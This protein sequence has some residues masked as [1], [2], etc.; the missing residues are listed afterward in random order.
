M[1][2]PSWFAKKS[3]C[4]TV[5]IGE[6]FSHRSATERSAKDVLSVVTLPLFQRWCRREIFNWLQ[7]SQLEK[8]EKV[9]KIISSFIPQNLWRSIECWAFS[10]S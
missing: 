4:T 6:I 1:D 9:G 8:Y 3:N 5:D 2:D 10:Q 7:W